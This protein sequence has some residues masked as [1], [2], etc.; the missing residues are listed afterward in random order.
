[1]RKESNFPERDKLPA[2]FV[3]RNPTKKRNPGALGAENLKTGMDGGH[4][5]SYRR[6]KS[7][8]AKFAESHRHLFIKYV[9]LRFVVY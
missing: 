2:R 7:E 3:S 4:A 8:D 1:M 9:K 6:W 5:H